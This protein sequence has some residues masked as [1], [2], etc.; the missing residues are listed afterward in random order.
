MLTINNSIE[1]KSLYIEYE[2]LCVNSITQE[3]VKPM[4]FDL[5]IERK[6]ADREDFL[7]EERLT[8]WLAPERLERREVFDN[9]HYY[10]VYSFDN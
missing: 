7:F 10:P 1:N 9:K 8:E 5:T 6:R 3:M 4:Q 2:G